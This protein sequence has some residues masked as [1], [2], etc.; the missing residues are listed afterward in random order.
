MSTQITLSEDQRLALEK[1]SA[2]I[3][4]DQ[5]EHIVAQGP[6]VLLARLDAF[7]SYEATLLGEVHEHVAAAMPRYMPLPNDEPRARPLVLSVKTFEGKEGENLLLW[8]REVEMA[9]NAAMLHSEQQRVG[10]AISKLG[11]RAK[12]WA[13]TCDASVGTAFPTLELLKRQMYRVFAPP[14]QAYRVRSRFLSCRQGKKELSDYVQELR[15]L[16]AAMQLDPLPEAVRITIFM[17]GLR[18]GV[19]RTEVF[20]VHPSTFEEAVD[21]ALNAGFNFKASR[22]GTH[23]DR[24]GSSDRAEPMDLSLAEEAELQAVEQQRNIRRCFMCGSTRHLRSSCPLRKQ[25]QHRPSRNPSPSQ[26]PGTAGENVNS[27]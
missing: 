26:K 11:G 24:S 23:G 25:P 3:G 27:Q 14:N 10:L 21:I 8:I 1:L 4:S 18:T 5:V 22:Y 19:A 2:L 17:E 20:R 6:E 15:T 9:M 16:L 7:R 13:L 12:E